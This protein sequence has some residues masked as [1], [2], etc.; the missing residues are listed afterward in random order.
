MKQCSLIVVGDLQSNNFTSTRM[1]KSVYDASWAQLKSQLRYKAVKHEVT[2][3]EVPEAYT[4]RQ[5]SCC[6]KLTGPSG[7]NDLNVREWKCSSCGS[8]RDRDVNA[9]LNILG[10]GYETLNRRRA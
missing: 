4:T 6:G 3:L 2:Y 7:S 5:C 9:A 8:L 10:L 1:A